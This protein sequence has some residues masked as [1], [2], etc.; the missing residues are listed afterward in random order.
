M[1]LEVPFYRPRP[2]RVRSFEAE[3]GM[4]VLQLTQALFNTP[5]T[6]KSNPVMHHKHPIGISRIWTPVRPEH[7]PL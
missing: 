6:S 2:L 7:I 1:P 5:H 4:S 3:L